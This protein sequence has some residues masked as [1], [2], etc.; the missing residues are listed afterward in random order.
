MGMLLLVLSCGTA[1][2]VLLVLRVDAGRTVDEDSM[3]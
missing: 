2:P 3:A 1:L